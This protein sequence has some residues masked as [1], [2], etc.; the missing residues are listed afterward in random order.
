M[1]S[2]FQAAEKKPKIFILT[3]NNLANARYL[4][5]LRYLYGGGIWIPGEE[6]LAAILEKYAR[7]VTADKGGGYPNQYRS[8]PGALDYGR[9]D[10]AQQHHRAEDR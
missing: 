3:Q 1:I 2:A 10:G 7:S 5:Y 8:R 9:G 6:E 4:K